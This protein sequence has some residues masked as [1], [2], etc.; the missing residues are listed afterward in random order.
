[1][2]NQSPIIFLIGNYMNGGVARRSTTLANEMAKCGRHVIILVTG[3]IGTDLP[4]LQPGV[5]LV[6]LNEVIQ[7]LDNNRL[8][9]EDEA[10][11]AK[12]LSW[13]RRF[14]SIGAFLHLN[15]LVTAVSSS[16]S[17]ITHGNFL[18]PFFLH[19]HNATII[20]FSLP[21][22][23][24][25]HC[26]TSDLNCTII[27]AEKNASQ[28]E[29]PLL[30]DDTQE[31]NRKLKYAKA[32][33]FQTYDEMAQYDRSILNNPVVIRNPI[34]PDLPLPF[35]GNRKK[36]IVNF[37]RFSTQKN[38][39]LLIDSFKLFHDEFP[40]YKLEI[41]GNIVKKEQ[42]EIK[43]YLEKKITINGLQNYVSILPPRLDV[44]KQII[45]YAMFVSSSDFEGLSNSM[46]EAMAIGLPCICTDCLG[47]GARE[48]IQNGENGLLV[49]M[50]NPIQL[51]NAMKCFI[52][53]PELAEK[54]GRNATRIREEL[55][56]DKIVQEWLQV[57]DK[58]IQL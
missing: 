8:V 10:R 24:E 28:L 57:I 31:G 19:H 3:E 52:Q 33:I 23:Y 4:P 5:E 36:I 49:P 1:M 56:A 26:A 14:R 38:L 58:V 34:R 29:N 42:L 22:V 30:A 2:R 39:P 6:L 13:L 25:A 21:F 18:R 51:C 20:A 16:I 15:G 40:E 32:C 9:Q 53:S 17:D 11:R 7:V 41:Y 47:G 44:H 50:N 37:C 35:H 45:D 46:L 48:I 27:F 12:R 55:S 54:C 43:N